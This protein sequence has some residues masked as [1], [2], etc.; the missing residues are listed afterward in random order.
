MPNIK[1][2]REL[3]KGDKI[4]FDN[5]VKSPYYYSIEWLGYSL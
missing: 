1:R 4:F 5:L 3:A 2:Y